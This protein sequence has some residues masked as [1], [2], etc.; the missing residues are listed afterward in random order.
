MMPFILALR[1]CTYNTVVLLIFQ[2]SVTH[3]FPLSARS[4]ST[5]CTA[6]YCRSMC[7]RCCYQSPR[8]ST[9]M[10]TCN[11]RNCHM[12][13]CLQRC[14][15]TRPTSTGT[16]CRCIHVSCFYRRGVLKNLFECNIVYRKLLLSNKFR[17]RSDRS[18]S[19]KN[20]QL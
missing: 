1:Y 18:N 11:R 12:M 6:V 5:T 3:R 2:F 4:T 19:L 13:Q 10:L 16:C 20:C 17:K 9:I 7:R 8:L 14:T 15:V